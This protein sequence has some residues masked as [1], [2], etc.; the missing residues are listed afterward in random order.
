[1]EK[2][3]YPKDSPIGED[4]DIVVTQKGNSIKMNNRTPRTYTNAQ[5]WLNQQYVRTVGE[6]TIGNSI[7]SNRFELDKFF[8]QHAEHFPTGGLLSPDKGQ[9]VVLAEIFDPVSGQRHRLLVRP[10]E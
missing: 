4:Y 5:L 10:K 1:M 8:S 7:L 6:I 9:L 2:M 3:V